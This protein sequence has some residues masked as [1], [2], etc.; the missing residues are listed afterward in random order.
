M[1]LNTLNIINFKN[2]E[3][4]DLAFAPKIN[5]F[6]GRNGMGKTNVLD[7]IYHLSFCKSAFNSIDSQN[8]RHGADFAL[9]QGEYISLSGSLTDQAETDGREEND[10]QE[11]ETI[12][13]GIRRGQKKQF[14]RGR[15]DYKR[16]TDHIGL[17]PLVLVSPRDSDLVQEGS[18][19][20]RRFLDGTLSQHDRTYLEHLTAYNALLKQRNALLKQAADS[21]AEPSEELFEVIEMQMATHAET[22]FRAR[23][24]FMESFLPVFREFYSAIAGPAEEVDLEYVS[25]L[26]DR[27][28]IEAYSRTR[29]RDLVLGWTSQGIHKDELA[30]SLAGYPLRRI[31][32][33]GQQKTY[34]IALKLAQAVWL[35]TYGN[36]SLRGTPPPILLLDDIFDKLDSERVAAIIRLVG[37][38]AFGQI[39]ITDTDRTRLETLFQSCNHQS[40]IF[41]VENG[42]VNIL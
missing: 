34:L 2:I 42:I 10:R 8:I 4:A 36:T 26:Q 13:C 21:G 32:S 15:K 39:F 19:E 20:R 28:L 29:A 18:D 9:V 6:V 38:D 3:Q 14:R 41:G 17:I 7:A 1:Y 12:T 25:Q 24:A 11:A 31:G 40:R 27:D 16:L 35:R 37:G 30:M 23:T 5:C 33:Q 22:V